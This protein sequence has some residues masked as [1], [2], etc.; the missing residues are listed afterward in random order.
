MPRK[1]KVIDFN[2]N[3]PNNGTEEL[4]NEVSSSVLYYKSSDAG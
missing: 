1:I 4:N 2:N 3:E